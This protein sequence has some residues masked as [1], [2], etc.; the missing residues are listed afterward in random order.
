LDVVCN[1]RF[2][3]G[4]QPDYFKY[5]RDGRRGAGFQKLQRSDVAEEAAMIGCVV[6]FGLPDQGRKLRDARH[7]QQEHDKQCFPVAV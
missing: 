1:R 3:G 6:C 4:G 2:G 5:G 7:A